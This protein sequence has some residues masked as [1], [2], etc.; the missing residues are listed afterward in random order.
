MS[1]LR[2]NEPAS[3][4]GRWMRRAF[5]MIPIC[6]AFAVVAL[7]AGGGMCRHCD[8][9]G[10][11]TAYDFSRAT[12]HNLRGCGEYE[13]R[14][15]PGLLG[16]A[17]GANLVA[18]G[19]ECDS[20]DRDFHFSNFDPSMSCPKGSGTERGVVDVSCDVFRE[21]LCLNYDEGSLRDDSYKVEVV[22]HESSVIVGCMGLLGAKFGLSVDD[23]SSPGVGPSQLDPNCEAFSLAMTR[24]DECIAERGPQRFPRGDCF[25]PFSAFLAGEDDPYCGSCPWWSSKVC[26][27]GM[28]TY[29]SAQQPE[30]IETCDSVTSFGLEAGA[31]SSS[32]V[33]AQSDEGEVD[34][35]PSRGTQRLHGGLE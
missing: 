21:A 30:Y 9:C 28:I 31:V 12:L 10:D 34:V 16:C 4:T 26:F 33:E 7:S 27:E 14:C 3:K 8:D 17:I 32:G 13:G 11:V 5:G 25:L 1:I 15:S 2:N 18:S 29:A 23:C 22:V 20:M 24:L 35:A 6:L 19:I